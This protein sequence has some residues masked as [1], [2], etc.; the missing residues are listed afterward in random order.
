[1]ITEEQVYKETI[2]DLSGDN[3]EEQ[4]LHMIERIAELQITQ[5]MDILQIRGSNGA[6]LVP[7]AEGGFLLSQKR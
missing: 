7:D 2:A 6:R 3:G 1:M 4:R 5:T